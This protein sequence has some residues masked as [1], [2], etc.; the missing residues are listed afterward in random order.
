MDDRVSLSYS[1][2]SSLPPFP[3]SPLSLPFLNRTCP[4]KQHMVYPMTTAVSAAGSIK[5]K[6]VVLSK[7][8]TGRKLAASRNKQLIWKRHLLKMY[9][10][11]YMA[12]TNHKTGTAKKMWMC[13]HAVTI[14][15]IQHHVI[16]L[17]LP[18]VQNLLSVTA[19]VSIRVLMTSSSLGKDDVI[20]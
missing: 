7:Q 4:Y 5:C 20:M 6:H 8:S 1:Y 19:H 12:S 15:T 11:K 17:Q 16:E 2:L 13:V 3:P 18:G 9:F 10:R 14:N